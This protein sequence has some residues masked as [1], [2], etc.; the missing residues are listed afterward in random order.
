MLKAI[1]SGIVIILACASHLQAATPLRQSTPPQSIA[2]LPSHAQHRATLD[3]YC[4]TCHNQRLRTAGLALDKLDLDNVGE[5]APAWE[6]A[7]RKL[8]SGA[9]P[10]AGMPRP[11]KAS[12]GSL[13]AYL[14][15]TVDRVA[16]AT[17]DPGR[18]TIHRLNRAEYANAVRDLLA[19]D[20]GAIDIESLLPADDAG[21]GFDNIGDVLSVSPVLLERYMSAARKISR[22]AIGVPPA[23]PEL[24]TYVA[25]RYFRQEDRISEDAP[26]GSRGGFMV[27][28]Y[29]PVDGEYLIRIRLKRTYDDAG[30]LG[31]FS[32]PQQLDLRLDGARLKLFP[33]GSERAGARGRDRGEERDRGLEVRIPVKAGPHLVDATFLRN[34]P[35]PEGVLPPRVAYQ[36][37]GTVEPREE[38][39]G[40]GSIMIGGPYTPRGPGETASRRKIFQCRPSSSKDED[41]CASKILSTL[42][43][44]AYRR[45]VTG[46]DVA[47]LFSLYKAGASKGGFESGMEMALRG[48][49]VS[50][51]FLF[52]IERDPPNVTPA[53]AYGISD[54]E[55]ASRLSFF[56]WSSI[57]DDEL[58]AVAER[59]AL[60]APAMLEQQ[61]RRMLAD[62]RAKSLVT[63][64]AGQWLFL[65]N[66]QKVIP[67]KK[68]FPYFDENLRVALQR[69]TELLFE[70]IVRE[71][72]SALDLLNADY[73]FLNERLARH[74]GIPNIYGSHFRRVP[75]TDENRKGLL[76]QGSILT[77]TSYA[78]RT[79]PT[80]RG[81]WLLESLL[82]APPPPPPPNVP[83]LQEEGEHVK[84]LTMRQRMEQHR[85]NP[86]CASCHAQM[87]PLGFALENFDA[88][89]VWRST[90]GT[91]G[92][93]IDASG[94]LPDGTKFTGPS[95]LRQILLSRHDQF[96]HVVIEKLLTYALGRGVEYY[97]MPAVRKIAEDA[98]PANYRWSALVL[99]IVK[100]TPFQMRRSRSS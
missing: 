74:Y 79:S 45:P 78:H 70:S 97:D 5:S 66:L 58:L 47:A 90:S 7:I 36:G 24:E 71:D 37:A 10:P 95:E 4:V 39:P 68:V 89:G 1:L 52:R 12:Y 3:R 93:P 65:R 50:P 63:N 69:E 51:N 38:E 85:T 62:A 49:L 21:Y 60:K 88:L 48:M 30:I 8:R 57:P 14:E 81:K 75:V 40:V 20:T 72:R 6:K 61:V 73:T 56:L 26:L 99:G 29:F 17:P 100:S 82:G 43:R 9:M 41:A 53:T 27:R 54:L 76:G 59:G 94:V 42:A 67:D 25:P 96:M 44:R 92:T 33:L 84:V 22:L 19:I 83:S 91:A 31:S 86:V 11:D 87:D 35:K 13:I 77:V 2:P 34:A 18:P 55:L 16:A 15:T 80:L 28:H 98:A 32:M 23:Q 46:P 64:F